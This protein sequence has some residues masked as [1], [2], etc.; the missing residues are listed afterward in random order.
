MNSNFNHGP[1]TGMEISVTKHGLL[2]AV[3]FNNGDLVSVVFF[4][5]KEKHKRKSF[6]VTFLFD[7]EK[8]TNLSFVVKVMLFFA[9]KELVWLFPPSVSMGCN[10]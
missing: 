2:S 1:E 5:Q 10:L 3:K 6:R 9:R 7:L 4:Y 8:K